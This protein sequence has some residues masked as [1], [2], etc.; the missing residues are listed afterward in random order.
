MMR[1]LCEIIKCSTKVPFEHAPLKL[2]HILLVTFS[3]VGYPLLIATSFHSRPEQLFLARQ[4]LGYEH[5]TN[6]LD[7]RT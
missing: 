1:R 4:I 7:F 6:H 3:L 2:K 5:D